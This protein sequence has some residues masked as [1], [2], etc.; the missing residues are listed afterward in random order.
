MHDYHRI[1]FFVEADYS[2]GLRIISD[3][4]ALPDVQVFESR[5]AFTIQIHLLAL[6]LTLHRVHK[7]SH[8]SH[9]TGTSLDSCLTNAAPPPPI[10]HVSAFP[11][12]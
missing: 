4:P 12:T 8:T 5:I 10:V 6:Q 11:V 3:E 9:E 1:T 7:S 2:L